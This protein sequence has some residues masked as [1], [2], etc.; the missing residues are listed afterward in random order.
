MKEGY[1]LARYL[2]ATNEP[3]AVAKIAGIKLCQAYRRQ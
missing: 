1:L 2:E 3:Y